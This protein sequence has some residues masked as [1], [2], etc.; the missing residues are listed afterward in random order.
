[1]VFCGDF[2]GT[3][4]VVTAMLRTGLI[5]LVALIAAARPASAQ[6]APGGCKVWQTTSQQSITVTSTRHYR[7]LRNV[8]VDCND[9]QFFADEVEV[10]SDPDRLHASGHV[11]FVSS[12]NRISADRVEFNT[13]TRTGTFYTASGIANLENRA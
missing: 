5:A 10:F 9:M 6:Q 4:R 13:R 12:S 11:V 7:L 2:T 3:F 1:M 8:E